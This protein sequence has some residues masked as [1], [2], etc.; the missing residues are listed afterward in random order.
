M[1]NHNYLTYFLARY[2]LYER[3]CLVVVFILLFYSLEIPLKRFK[4][5]IKGIIN[6]FE[7][8]LGCG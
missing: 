1:L 8:F 7:A 2:L 3:S 6:N 4:T 5:K